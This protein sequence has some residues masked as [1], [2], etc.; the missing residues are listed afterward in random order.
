[1][2]LMTIIVYPSHVTIRIRYISIIP[3]WL[4]M[5]SIVLFLLYIGNSLAYFKRPSPRGKSTAWK[6]KLTPESIN[7]VEFVSFKTA[8]LNHLCWK[9]AIE[10]TNC[11]RIYLHLINNGLGRFRLVY[12]YRLDNFFS[13]EVKV[14]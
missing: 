6:K 14:N 9:W 1:M 7:N 12:V 3:Q 2:K 5:L 4:T 13:T 11:N 10:V 8:F